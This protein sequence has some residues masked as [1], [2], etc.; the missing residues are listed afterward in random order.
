MKASRFFAAAL[1]L[2]MEG[3]NCGSSAPTIKSFT[4]TPTA[5]PVDGGTVTLAWEVDGANSLTISNG[6]GAVTPLTAGTAS[7]PV[8]VATTYTLTATNPSGSA[9]ATVDVC[10]ATGG[11]TATATAPSVFN[12]CA[13]PF[14]TAVVLDNGTCNAVSVTRAVI[15]TGSGQGA[16]SLNGDYTLSASV[17]PL[18]SLSVLDLQNGNIC[19]NSYPCS[20]SCS[21]VPSWT[22]TTNAG[23]IVATSTNVSIQMADC[24]ATHCGAPDAGSS[25]NGLYAIGGTVAISEQGLVLQTPGEPDLAVNTQGAAS[26]AWQFANKVSPGTSYNVTVKTQPSSPSLTTCTVASGG[27]GTVGNADVV[28]ILVTCATQLP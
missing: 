16:C 10:V 7:A 4:A 1:L 19:C 9:T 14:T 22:L 17:P 5:L 15:A 24:S 18:R 27:V 23:P 25:G 28:N 8:T 21:G 2:A 6:I 11:I 12:Q 26:D 3:C 20:I 13:Q